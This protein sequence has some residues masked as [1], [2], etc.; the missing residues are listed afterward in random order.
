MLRCHFLF[1][2]SFL[3]EILIGGVAQGDDATRE[4]M[5]VILRLQ[6][7]LLLLM[8]LDCVQAILV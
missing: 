3:D 6:L 1:D 8:D 2:D 4:S 5:R 7:H